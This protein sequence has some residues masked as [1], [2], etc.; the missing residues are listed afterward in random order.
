MSF[1]GV[2]VTDDLDM[3]AIAKHYTLPAIV[4]Q[5]LLSSIDILL[6]CHPGPKIKA[7]FDHILALRNSNEIIARYE[8]DSLE[9]ILSLKERYLVD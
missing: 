8:E 1:Q 4:A 7:A 2:V 3:G 9:R 6:I 5:A